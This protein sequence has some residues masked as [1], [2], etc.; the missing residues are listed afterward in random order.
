MNNDLTYLINCLP[1]NVSPV[2]IQKI[3]QKITSNEHT[4][5]IVDDNNINNVVEI[6]QMTKFIF[7][8]M[9]EYLWE[10]FCVELNMEKC[11]H[12]TIIHQ[13]VDGDEVELYD[14]ILIMGIIKIVCSYKF[15]LP[16]C[17]NKKIKIYGSY[18]IDLSTH[19]GIISLHYVQNPISYNINCKKII[20][21]YTTPKNI[22]AKHIKIYFDSS[23]E[24]KYVINTFDD[25]NKLHTKK[26]L[27]V[28]PKIEILHHIHTNYYYLISSLN[29][30]VY[31]DQLEELTDIIYKMNLNKLKL[32]IGKNFG[33][34]FINRKQIVCISHIISHINIVTINIL[35]NIS[36]EYLSSLLQFI[37]TF[38][39]QSKYIKLN[40]CTSLEIDEYI[41]IYGWD[42]M[43][44]YTNTTHN[45]YCKTLVD[46][47]LF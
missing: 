13:L 27:L 42:F 3:V 35:H 18:P 37:Y 46:M 44:K 29:I 20:L 9:L 15:I 43:N 31:N 33:T 36:K 14:N 40:Y 11:T 25:I 26:I 47:H 2:D 39:K 19:K 34:E 16:Y 38:P 28:C 5:I 10:D 23:T 22:L 21:Q 6:I 30:T 7:G 45:K 8:C 12:N 4:K 32:V 1:Q 41:T 17:S 24:K